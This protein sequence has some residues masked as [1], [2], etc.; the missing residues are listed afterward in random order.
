MLVGRDVGGGEEAA[1]VA[2]LA[3]PPVLVGL[4]CHRYDVTAAELQLT[5]LLKCSNKNI[6]AKS[7]SNEII[8]T[9]MPPTLYYGWLKIAIRFH[10]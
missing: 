6:S 8:V 4:V 7:P 2:Q 5:L 10:V 1:P 3:R 9:K